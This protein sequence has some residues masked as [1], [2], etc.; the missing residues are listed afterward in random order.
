[1]KTMDGHNDLHLTRKYGILLPINY[2]RELYKEKCT[3]YRN[4][5]SAHIFASR[6]SEAIGVFCFT[7]IIG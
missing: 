7:T 5:C 2:Y 1:M 3:D 4:Q 6:L